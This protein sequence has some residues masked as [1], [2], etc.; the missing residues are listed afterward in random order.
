VLG[1]VPDYM[2]DTLRLRW[3]YSLTSRANPGVKVVTVRR[4]GSVLSVRFWQSRITS[5]AAKYAASADVGV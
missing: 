4:A 2:I 5:R 3:R 1:D